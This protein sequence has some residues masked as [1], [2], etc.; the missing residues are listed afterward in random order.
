MLVRVSREQFTP[1]KYLL[2]A[3]GCLRYHLEDN[4]D[5]SDHFPPAIFSPASNLPDWLTGAEAAA[6]GNPSILEQYSSS[7][8]GQ[9]AYYWLP[10]DALARVV[11]D[12]FVYPFGTVP[13]CDNWVTTSVV[14]LAETIDAR[15]AF[16]DMPVLGDALEDA[17]CQDEYVLRHCRHELCHFRGCWALDLVLDKKSHHP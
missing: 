12:L 1:R 2:L 6:D 10:P 11:R 7:I 15:G 8:P 14:A 9:K 5:P 3:C 16:E 4:L 17:G 13:F